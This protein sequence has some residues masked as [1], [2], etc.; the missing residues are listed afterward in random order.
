MCNAD[1]NDVCSEYRLKK[2][3]PAVRGQHYRQY[4]ESMNV[5]VIDSGLHSA[6][7]NTKA[8]NDSLRELLE[9]RRGAI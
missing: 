4:Q 5:V 2:L 1:A 8:V 7:P 6:F 3:G 9:S